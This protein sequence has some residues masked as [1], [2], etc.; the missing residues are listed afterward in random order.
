MQR[1][2]IPSSPATKCPKILKKIGL[3]KIFAIKLLFSLRVKMLMTA[4]YCSL[5]LISQGQG[6]SAT[7]WAYVRR[8][9]KWQS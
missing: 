6:A 4:S 9:Q 2:D 7:H 3:Y 8:R 5:R 1:Y